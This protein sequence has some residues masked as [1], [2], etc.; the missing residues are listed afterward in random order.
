MY[1]TALTFTNTTNQA[2]EVFIDNLKGVTSSEHI[3][4]GTVDGGYWGVYHINT[5]EPLGMD[6]SD[7][8]FAGGKDA[9]M[10]MPDVPTPIVEGTV[11][12]RVPSDTSNIEEVPKAVQAK[13][14]TRG[15]FMLRL[16]LDHPEFDNEDAPEKIADTLIGLAKRMVQEGN[17]K[18]FYIVLSSTDKENPT[19]GTAEITP[20]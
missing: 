6:L 17:L 3:D 8:Q 19:V 11:S 13:K 16:K 2:V 15:T 12:G 7:F 14:P 4:S 18:P 1:T 10:V 20:N 9:A 5:E